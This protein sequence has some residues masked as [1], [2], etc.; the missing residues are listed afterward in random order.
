MKAYKKDQLVGKLSKKNSL[1]EY[2]G[3]IYLL[4]LYYKEVI[5]ENYNI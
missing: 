4:K 2:L 1:K 3:K 5:R